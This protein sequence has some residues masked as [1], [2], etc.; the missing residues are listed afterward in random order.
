[1]ANAKRAAVRL[2]RS[3][4]ELLDEMKAQVERSNS[5]AE[6]VSNLWEGE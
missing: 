5:V 4:Q 1:M 3:E 6:L 2:P